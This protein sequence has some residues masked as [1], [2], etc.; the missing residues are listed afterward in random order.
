MFKKLVVTLSIVVASLGFTSV[1]FAD[2]SVK[3]DI[4]DVALENGSLKTFGEALKTANL[5]DTLKSEGPFTVFA[6]TD[7]AFANLPEGT[8]ETLLEPE[9]KSKLTAILSYHIVKSKLTGNDIV[10]ATS[11]ETSQGQKL[12]VSTAGGRVM[13]NNAGVSMID[14]KASNGV[15]HV[16]DTVLMPKE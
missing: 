12:T 1:V 14:V 11:F 5:V 16:I 15:I 13:I 2:D 7:K 3:N 6:P 9:N 8:L 10:K 4:V